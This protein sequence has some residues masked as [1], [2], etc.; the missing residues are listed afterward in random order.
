M[1]AEAVAHFGPRIQL[2]CVGYMTNYRQW[3]MTGLSVIDVAQQ[4]RLLWSGKKDGG[5]W[6]WRDM[7]QVIAKWRQFSEP[8]DPVVWVDQL[9]PEQFA[10]G[11]G[12]HTPMITG[13]TFVVRYSPMY[14]KA[15]S[16]M[17]SLIH[18]VGLPEKEQALFQEAK[19]L[20]EAYEIIGRDFYVCT[21]CH[22]VATPGRVHEGTRLTLQVSILHSSQHQNLTLNARQLHLRDLNSVY[23][24]QEPLNVGR[25]TQKRWTLPSNN[26][27]RLSHDRK[28]TWMRYLS[29]Y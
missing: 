2:H 3:A 1:I 17:K 11:F 15:F 13:Q 23:A 6:G 26:S 18:Q 8:N 4:L 27:K 22:S 24:L 29:A 5:K 25:T 20:S 14:P 28:E 12:A 16:I 19:T 9:S 21:P 7:Y 10:E